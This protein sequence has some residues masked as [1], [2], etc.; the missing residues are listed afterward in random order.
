MLPLIR[1]AGWEIPLSHRLVAGI[2][3]ICLGVNPFS[4]F[5]FAFGADCLAGDPVL[6]IEEPAD[7]FRLEKLPWLRNY[8]TYMASSYDHEGGN[9][10]WGN[11]TRTQGSEGVILDVKGSGMITRI[12]SANP[13][14]V[15]R[16]Y[17]DDNQRPVVEESF[18]LFLKRL[19]M[20]IGSGEAVEP[21]PHQPG[22]IT[23]YFPIAFQKS[24]KLTLSPAPEIYYQVNYLLFDES[25][26]L[27]P[28]SA[29]QVEAGAVQSQRITASLDWDFRTVNPTWRHHTGV[30][31]LDHGKST[32]VFDQTGPL[33]IRQITFAIKWPPDGAQ[34][35]CAR[36]NLLLR[37][38]W[39]EDLTIEGQA[40]RRIASIKSPLACFFMDF[41]TLSEYRT[42]LVVKQ[43]EQCSCRFPMPV[44]Q[45]AVL[46]LLNHSPLDI[47]KV[48]YDI[49]YELTA[50]ADMPATH[51]KALYHSE[52][53]T[54]GRDLGN[55]RDQVMYLRNGGEENYPLLR[56]RG[57][58]HVIGCCFDVDLSETPYT[59]AA[60]ESDEVVFADD[61]PQRTM[62]GTGNED[63]VNDAWGFHDVVGPLSGGRA[64][65]SEIF[66]YRFHISDA[67]AFKKK[68]AFTL[69][70]G[71]SNNCTGKFRSVVYY[72]LRGSGPNRF[73]DGVP[74]RDMKQYFDY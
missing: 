55:Y 23:S 35:S 72:Y 2:V 60:G 6:K 50:A 38:Y 17:I 18:A 3:F 26:T 28:F 14:G 19:P 9:F 30:V 59:R 51:F 70:H 66:G 47:S 39:D 74:G 10:D 57:E 24:C 13:D 46:E 4:G 34:A 37:G 61:D 20:R 32:V 45:R 27:K 5:E 62:W 40:N 11:Y 53:S 69:E 29:S 63:Y 8:R 1:N 42:A 12:W 65:H 52:D 49:A 7:L 21:K 67:I 41:G 44:Q 15:V 73:V 16:L 54:F 33:T 68:L 56:V 64:T 71:S 48:S 58:G 22:G 31:E 36:E 43:G 25:Q